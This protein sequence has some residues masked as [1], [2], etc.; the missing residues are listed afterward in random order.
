ML[1]SCLVFT[2]TTQL[3]KL[4]NRTN[5][6]FNPFNLNLVDFYSS[7]LLCKNRKFKSIPQRYFILILMVTVSLL[8]PTLPD[9][10]NKFMIFSCPFASYFLKCYAIFIVGF[11]FS[12]VI[13]SSSSSD[14]KVSCHVNI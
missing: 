13:S 14:R 6:S 7:H 4:P 10:K 12:S 5:K 1:L 2:V 8:S 11:H 9:N 3:T